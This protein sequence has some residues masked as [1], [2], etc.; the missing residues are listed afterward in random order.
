MVNRVTGTAWRAAV[1]RA[2]SVSSFAFN[3][4][5]SARSAGLFAL[6][7]GSQ[8]FHGRGMLNVQL[9][10]GL[11]ANQRF[12]ELIFDLAELAPEL[13]HVSLQ[14]LEFL[15]VAHTATVQP[16]LGAG[17][18]AAC[19]TLSGLQLCLNGAAVRQVGFG[20]RET[21]PGRDQR[22]RLPQRFGDLS[23]VG[24]SGRR[25]SGRSHS[26]EPKALQHASAAS[27]ALAS[28]PSIRIVKIVGRLYPMA[29]AGPSRAWHVIPTC[30]RMQFISNHAE[31]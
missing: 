28:K 25:S 13:R 1:C 9:G 26:N 15:G 6:P 20:R 4:A 14:I 5:C 18:L 8:P 21:A 7:V 29:V 12:Q 2:V 11:G 19:V 16:R 10:R 22:G 30:A 24:P 17:E 23:R 27:P 3:W 31:E